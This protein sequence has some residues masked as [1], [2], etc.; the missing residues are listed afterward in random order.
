MW[1]DNYEQP[2]L[3]ELNR[4][5]SPN[6][7]GFVAQAER[8]STAVQK[9][10]ESRGIQKGS[11]VLDFGAGVGRVALR[12]SHECEFPTHACDINPAA[13]DYLGSQL[14]N[15]E[16]K[17]TPYE[18]PLPYPDETFDVVY[19]ISIWTHL[20]EEMGERWLKEI[21]RILKPRGLALISTSGVKVISRRRER[22][23]LGWENYTVEDLER[24]GVLYLEYK[25]LDISKQ[26]HPGVTAS[27]GLTAHHPNFIREE[28]SKVMPVEQILV[29]EIDNIQDLV[30]MRRV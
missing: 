1:Y 16:C 4:V 24:A 19:S 28:W 18:P 20:P 15:V 8:L 6:W 2:P 22:G 12:L 29:E 11:K 14:T 5:G 13:M 9:Q 23:D 10:L 30:V 7:E 21:R 17:T 27:Y 25:N 3:K 26:T